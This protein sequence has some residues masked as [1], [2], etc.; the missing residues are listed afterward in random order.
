MMTKSMTSVANIDALFESP[1]E[2]SVTTQVRISR[3]H[4]VPG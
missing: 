3:F 4:S 2:T 1:R